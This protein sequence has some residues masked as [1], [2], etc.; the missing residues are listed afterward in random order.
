LLYNEKTNILNENVNIWLLFEKKFKKFTINSVKSYGKGKLIKFHDFNTRTDIES[1][2]SSKTLFMLRTDFPKLNKKD[3]YLIDLIGL[4]VIN[5]E[6]IIGKV[7]DII[8]FPTNNSILISNKKKQE[9]IIPI[10]D[11]FI[12]FFDFDNNC[13]IIKNS[14]VFLNKC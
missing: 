12:E 14:E 9:F 10:M 8:V 1:I 7:I 13:I 2:F 6:L 3:F 11:Q 5:K 4:D